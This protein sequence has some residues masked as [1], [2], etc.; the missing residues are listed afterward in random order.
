MD[1]KF[2]TY[3]LEI[4]KQKSLSRAAERLFVGQSAL[5]QFLSREETQLGVKLFERQNGKLELTYAGKLYAECCKEIQESQNTLY[6][7]ISEIKQSKT[8]ITRF[9]ITPQWGGMIYSLIYPYFKVR[10]PEYLLRITEDVAHP[11]L[12]MLVEK[13]LDIALLALDES[14]PSSLP[15]QLIHKEQLVLAV[16]KSIAKEQQIYDQIQNKLPTINLNNFHTDPFILSCGK[17]IIRD[18]SYRM[19]QSAKFTPNI[20][21]EINNHEASLQMVSEGVGIAIIPRCYMRK[22]QNICY[23]SV[24]PG[25]YW[26]IS[27]VS[28]VDY[29]FTLADNYFISLLKTYY[30]RQC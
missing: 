16:P 26:N 22:D 9:G 6:R 18:I 25:W 1:A 11:L 8:G 30:D 3:F 7:K 10:Y 12:E 4:A 27:I 13:N 5:S 28:R 2:Q 21:C 14:T 20:V 23:Y 15:C 29:D 17:T 24:S 19:I